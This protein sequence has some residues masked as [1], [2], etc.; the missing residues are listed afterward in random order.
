MQMGYNP[1]VYAWL[2]F[3]GVLQKKAVS[4]MVESYVFR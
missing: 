4:K 1:E 2:G 3:Q